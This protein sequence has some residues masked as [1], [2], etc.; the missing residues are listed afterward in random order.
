[1]EGFLMKNNHHSFKYNLLYSSLLLA[2]AFP[3]HAWAGATF[4]GTMDSGSTASLSGNFTVTEADGSLRGTNLFHS[5]SDFNIHSG[6][7][8]TFTGT[9]AINN[10]ISRVTG[11]GDTTINGQLTSTI[12]GA[13]FYFINPNG[14]LFKEGASINVDGSFYAS[15]ADYVR[16]GDD[17]TF[18]ASNTT[19]SSLTSSPPSSFGFLSNSPADISLQGAQL[20]KG[21]NL[22]QPDNTSF[23]LIARNI[24]LDQA[25]E[26]TVTQYGGSYS[27]GSFIHTGN[28]RFEIIS[29]AS[30]GEVVSTV[31]GYDLASFTELG[32]V[33]IVNG[34]V[35]D[36]TDVYIRGGNVTIENS[37]IAPG[38]FYLP[39]FYSSLSNPYGLNI[40]GPFPT[41]TEGSQ[42]VAPNGGNIDIS[43]TNQVNIIG[44]SPLIIPVLYPGFE[45]LGLQMLPRPNFENYV[46]GITTYGGNPLTPLV[47]APATDVTN[48]NIN[49]SNVLVSGNAGIISER[50]GAGLAGNINIATNTLDV[51]TG[52]LI[53]NVNTFYGAGGNITI[54]AQQVTLASDP[55]SDMLTGIISTNTFNPLF[56][57]QLYPIFFSPYFSHADSGNITISATGTGGLTIKNGAEIST[58]S[59]AL[60]KAGNISITAS[61]INLSRNGSIYGAI[62]SQSAYAGNAGNISI[63]ST[64]D[65]NISGGFEIA[66][67]VQG[68]GTGGNISVSAANTISITGEGSGIASATTA[69]SE[70]VKNQLARRYASADFNSLINNINYFAGGPLL[71]PDANMFAVMSALQSL[72]LINLLGQPAV[73]GN[74]GSIT[75]AASTL[76]MNDNSRI[77]TSTSSDGNG[78]ALT[79]NVEKLAMKNNSEIRSRSGLYNDGQLEVGSGNGGDITIDASKSISMKSGSSISANSLGTGLAGDIYLDAGRILDLTD[80][81]ITTQATVADG[82]N[83][84]IRALDM[85]YLDQSGITT[86]V[87][88]GLGSGGNIDIDP[89]FFILRGS[90]ILA[91]AYGG[92]G[93]NIVLVANHFIT[94]ADSSID[95]SSALGMDGSIDI[96]SPDEEVADDLVVL[97]DN[98]M[99]VTSLISERCGASSGSSSLVDAGSAGMSVDPDG[100]LPSYAIA[101]AYVNNNRMAKNTNSNQ[102]HLAF[103]DIDKS[104]LSLAQLSCNAI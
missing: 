44:N 6:E 47:G 76:N 3:Y 92:D 13:D 85:I 78:G 4:D 23:S 96:S 54:D 69:P 24:T 53:A 61:D 11:S 7:S 16:F 40:L 39:Y 81:S 59:Y 99:D 17:S 1:M 49:T 57:I 2:C 43:A 31:D 90:N 9:S 25:A 89:E 12:T 41:P 15:T 34:S 66:A 42:I 71:Q 98:Y 33:S 84:T 48:I 5:F 103:A 45:Y 19:T 87:E 51:Q 93:G 86:S 18:S 79:I 64:N 63:E 74:A 67:S 70:K 80:S 32:D 102:N 26:D 62:A 77:T 95:A 73:A 30:S 50:Y 56:G 20:I 91:N 38:F 29:V 46:A 37:I 97:P 65:I 104:Q 52:G 14:I 68:I 88:N 58:D 94:S 35:I 28:D 101:E 60:G 100:Y 83:I 27:K 21:F 36:S 22:L 72:G 82:G 55:D 75:L 8:A 10:V